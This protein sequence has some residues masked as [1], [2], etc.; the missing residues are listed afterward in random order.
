MSQAR[1]TAALCTSLLVFAWGGQEITPLPSKRFHHAAMTAQ[2]HV[3]VV[4][5]TL[6]SPKTTPIHYYT[7]EYQHS[8]HD[9]QKYQAHENDN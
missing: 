1:Q 9:T 5:E 8:L 4:F 2:L 3:S 7:N 6:T